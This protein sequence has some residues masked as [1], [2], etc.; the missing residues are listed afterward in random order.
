[1]PHKDT[2]VPG[3]KRLNLTYSEYSQRALYEG[4]DHEPI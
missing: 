2:A 1:M 4:V 3:I